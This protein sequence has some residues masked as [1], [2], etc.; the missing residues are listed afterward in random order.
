MQISWAFEYISFEVLLDFI[1]Q[2]RKSVQ[3]NKYNK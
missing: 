3:Y 2:Q 1:H